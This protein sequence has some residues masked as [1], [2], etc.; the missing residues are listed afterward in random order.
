MSEASQYYD[1]L[2]TKVR[3]LRLNMQRAAF[4]AI[5]NFFSYWDNV[6]TFVIP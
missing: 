4:T 5:T 1:H 2:P 6:A 3:V